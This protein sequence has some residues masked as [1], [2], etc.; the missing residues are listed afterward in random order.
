MVC[1]CH[2]NNMAG[3][4]SSTTGTYSLSFSVTLITCALSASSRF[5]AFNLYAV[6][7]KQKTKI[8]PY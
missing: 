7:S 6:L 8:P 1:V 2:G 3:Y 4:D 5:L